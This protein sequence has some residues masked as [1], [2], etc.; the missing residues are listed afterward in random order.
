LN[1]V[2]LQ[3][4]TFVIVAVISITILLVILRNKK[5]NKYKKSITFLDK[6]KNQLESAPVIAELSKIETIIKNDRLEEKYKSWQD[7]FERI[8]GE[9][10]S[11]MNDYIFNLETILEH[12]E[13][14]KFDEE[15][16][17][18]ELHLYKIRTKINNLL[19][20]IKEIN[21]SEEKYRDIIIKLKA[22]YR[23][24]N[25]KFEV[26]KDSYD[27]IESIV[28][29][30]FEN[31]ERRFQDF[32]EFMEKNEYSEVI[33]IVKAIDTMIDHMSIV[34]EEAPD[35][36]LLA[37][38]VIPKRI[39]QIT[40]IYEEMKKE[41][42]PLEYLNVDYNIEESLK[43]V[44]KIFD[45]I[46]V[47]NLEDCM[48]E[49]RTMLDY[50]DSIFNEF[51]KE[52]ISRK[53]YEDEKG[54]F[55]EKLGRI[56]NIVKDVYSQIEEIKN[57]YDLT[58]K[59]I[60]IID[61]VNLRLTSLKKDYKKSI[62]KLTNSKNPY[63]KISK[64]LEEYTISLNMIEDDLDE[65]LKSLGN[66]Y[67]DEM[68][69]HE[70]LDEIQELLKESKLRIRKYKLP[71]ISN[72]YFVQLNEANEAILE[73]IKE[74][75]QKPITIQTL[76]TRVDT[77]RDLVLKLY[78]T[79][80]EMIK[81]AST[82]ETII[83]YGNKFRSGNTRVADGLNMAENL[84]YKGK[85]DKALTTAINAIA[86]VD[87]DIKDKVVDIYAKSWKSILKCKNVL[88]GYNKL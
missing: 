7:R 14:K 24:L 19:E 35:L 6:E 36:V 48:F 21:Q 78:N 29:L 40:E 60:K 37:T 55:E 22:K 59:D 26:N 28:E 56:A 9:D 16:S 54:S 67:D 85:Y 39:E 13:Y 64:E 44:N 88:L 63:S 81:M 12:R 82:T 79:T 58:D 32:E 75:E 4:M 18:A 45:R 83:V 50:L 5:N 23:E 25:S 10:I 33:H 46:K 52:K 68:R 71:L 41:N 51:D 66:M 76:N 84:F 1:P 8:K 70:Q 74:L 15:Y 2:V 17:K 11:N 43:N 49:L 3:T 86:I 34:V 65:T 61:D 42:Y 30:Q 53:D 77:A 31:I 80:N 57:M 47:L 87:K 27:G 69:A 38:K 72:T 20:E 62:K 73:I